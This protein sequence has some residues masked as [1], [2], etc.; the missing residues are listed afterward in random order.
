MAA[1]QDWLRDHQDLS[2]LDGCTTR[3]FE[4][5]PRSVPTGWLHRKTVWGITKICPYWMAAPQDCLRDH[6][7]LSL[8]DGCSTTLF[9]GS[10][11]ICPYCFKQD[12]ITLK[13]GIILIEKIAFLTLHASNQVLC[14]VWS[15]DFYDRKTV[16]GITKICPY[17]MA[18][19][20]DCLRD[21]QDLSLLDGCSTTLFEGSPKICPYCFKQ[22][23][24]TLKACI[25]L[26]EKIALWKAAAQHCLRDHQDLSKMDG[27]STRLFEGSPRSVPTGWLQHNTVWGITKICPYWMAAAQDCLRDHQDL[28][29]LDGCSTTL[30][31][32][33]PRTGQTWWLQR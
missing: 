1:A 32:G 30:F 16:W 17:W 15:Y 2:L 26:I 23:F 6:Q 11:K 27:C 4:G 20:Q 18:A 19:P 12:F 13:A 3:P 10:P 21:H 24:I 28:S 25:I 31:E 8:L 22:D 9:E 29:L 33:S 14:N 5:S 7:D